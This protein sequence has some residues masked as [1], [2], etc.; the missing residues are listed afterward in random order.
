MGSQSKNI[1]IIGTMDTK[2]EEALYMAEIIKNRGHNALL[3]DIGIGGTVPFK[4]EFTREE[5]ALATGRPFGEVIASAAGRY[6]DALSTMANGA[7][8]IIE[9]LNAQRKIDGLLSL[10]GSQ[11]TCQAL[12][13][14]RNLPL[15][16]SKF[17]IS[18][19]AFI[20][21]IINSEVVS[22][23]Q[24]MSQSVADLEGLNRITRLALQRAAG[25]ICGMV[26]EQKEEEDKKRAIAISS[27]GVFEYAGHCKKL[28]QE[29]GYE[30]IVFHSV[31][32]GAMEKII[33][34]GYV[35]GV[36][37]LTCYELI[38]LVTGG[39]IRGGEEKFSAACEKGIPQVIAPG[40][41]DFFP[42]PIAM[43]FPDRW[44]ERKKIRHGFVDLVMTLPEEQK[45][46]AL[47][48]ATKIN[49]TTVPITVLVPL[50]GFSCLDQSKEMPFYDFGAGKRFAT[51]L[52]ENVS[53][54]LVEIEEIDAHINDPVFVERA[55]D[56]L[57]NNLL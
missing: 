10:G 16:I 20:A 1:L 24:A 26:E 11:G 40:A 35:S 2:A 19:V 49:K 21:E 50:F 12:T 44:V 4:P 34:Q 14:M 32:T 42:W 9:E 13:I 55:T 56:L 25:A 47:R 41:L 17:A 36:L 27:L 46:T 45:E 57:L 33:Q 3:M 53:N 7:K 28:L 38:N 52:R 6:A 23:D 39:A 51:V 29:K 54:P 22:I 43:P 8:A 5:V 18:T 37:D 48:L 15:R 31:G 30:P